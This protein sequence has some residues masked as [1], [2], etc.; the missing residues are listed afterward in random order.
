VPDDDRYWLSLGA[1]WQPNALNR[2]DFGYAFIQIKDTEIN[3]DQTARARGVV[4]GTY[5]ADVHVFSVQYQFT[6]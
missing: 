3:N 4:R 6:F 1:T 2:F 5:Q